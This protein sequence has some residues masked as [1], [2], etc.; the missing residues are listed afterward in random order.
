[1]FLTFSASAGEWLQV[2]PDTTDSI[3]KTT[4]ILT[5]LLCGVDGDQSADVENEGAGYVEDSAL[6]AIRILCGNRASAEALRAP[7]TFRQY[8]I[9][10]VGHVPWQY[11]H[12][13]RGFH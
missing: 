3:V 11:D 10:P 5:N 6:G 7:D 4:C 9:S 2:S 13:C 8:F 1:M 12:V